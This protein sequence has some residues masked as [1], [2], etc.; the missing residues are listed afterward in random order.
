[1]TT[2]VS[3][4]LME[5]ADI[6]GQ[7]KKLAYEVQR[8][9]RAQFTT[10]PLPVPLE[11]IAAALGIVEIVDH[12]TEAFDGTLIVKGEKGAV[13]IRKGMTL[14][15]RRFTL[16]HEIGHFANPF[17]RLARSDFRCTA[18]DMRKKRHGTLEW[19]DRPAWDRIEIEANEFSNALLLPGPEFRSARSALGSDVDIEHIV[20]LA[21]TFG[22]SLEVLASTYVRTSRDMLAVITSKD[23]EVRR[24]MAA[25]AF[26]FLGLKKGAPVPAPSLTRT[27]PRIYARRTASVLSEV[28]ADTWLD[29]S[30]ADQ[31]L[32][33][34]VL[35]LANGCAMTLLYVEER[36]VD[37]DEDDTRWNRRNR[38]N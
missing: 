27:F 7:P 3:I 5:L 18:V 33:E 19:D 2:S 24:V 35:V 37:E 10:V 14:G 31:T 17:H 29:R 16:G 15:R 30:T 28:A 6:G 22:V 23:G 13:A 21:Q 20:S 8:Q 36:E 34:Q 4:D 25:T 1:M 12:E 9:L 38:Y 11:E 32:Y 26:P